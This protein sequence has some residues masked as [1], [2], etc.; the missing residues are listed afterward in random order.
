MA[1]SP[2]RRHR[3]GALGF[4]IAHA[5]EDHLRR[6]ARKGAIEMIPRRVSGIRCRMQDD[7]APKNRL[8]V[9]LAEWPRRPVAGPGKQLKI[10]ARSIRGFFQPRAD[11]SAGVVQGMSMREYRHSRR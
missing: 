1:L 2:T 10:T 11:Y 9:E 5:A 7:D 4:K 8:P 3:Q 6:W